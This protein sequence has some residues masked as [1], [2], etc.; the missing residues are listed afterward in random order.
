[1]YVVDVNRYRF[2]FWEVQKDVLGHCIR[3]EIS[4]PR[5][6]GLSVYQLFGTEKNK[7]GCSGDTFVNNTLNF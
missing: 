5:I 7:Q 1:M 2:Y 4:A 3:K 6:K